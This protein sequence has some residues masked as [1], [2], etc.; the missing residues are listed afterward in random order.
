[1]SHRASL[2]LV[3][4]VVSGCAA[5]WSRP[6]TPDAD[7]TFTAHR[8]HDRIVVDD[9]GGGRRA[10]LRPPGWF[11]GLG[12]PTFQLLVDGKPVA[13]LRRSA[14]RVTVAAG[15]APV[16]EVVTSWDQQAVGLRLVPAGGGAFRT[17]A[18]LREGGGTGFENLT[19]AAQTNLDVRGTFRAVVHDPA[20][21]PVGWIRVRIT[22]YQ[23]ASRIYD[24]RLPPALKPELVA[25]AAMALDA[26]VD[27]IEDHV[28]DVYRGTSGGPLERSVPSSR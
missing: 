10:E 9:L 26:E 15:G 25:G 11:H 28:L 22:P 24:A 23:E 1:M 21:A 17:D 3:A 18:F 4:A 8:E 6:V 27:W 13:E 5:T 19:R 14:E 12:A 20:G 7:A 2:L 16:G